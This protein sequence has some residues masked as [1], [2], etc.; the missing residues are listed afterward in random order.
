[1]AT[2]ILVVSSANMDLNMK[3]SELPAKG[4]TIMGE[5]YS[6][7][8]GGKGANSA[9]AFARLGGECCFCAAVGNDGNGDIL[10]DVYKKDGI[11]TSFVK[12]CTDAPT[13][14]A[15]VMVEADGANRIC[16][17]SGANSK[18]EPSDAVDAINGTSP[19]ALFC[20]FEIP[21]STVKAALELC[22][23]KGIPSFVD[24]GPASREYPLE[25]LPCVTVF[26]PN[27]TETEIYTGIRPTDTASCREA[28]EKLLELV[29]ARYIV[30]KLGGKGA[31]VYDCAKKSDPVIVPSYDVT[32]VDTTSAGDAFTAALALEYTRSGDMLRACRYGNVVGALTVSRVGAGDSVPR[33][34][35]CECFIRQ[36][37]IEL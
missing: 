23:R 3:L 7:V 22:S 9:T 8:P 35:E 14:L 33:A 32:V 11:D 19:D 30:I 5:G 28:A 31:A 12:R 26:S 24:A 29:K 34:D 25:E 37:G 16:V 4:R 17:F 13:G 20:H 21:F 1:M 2:K 10:L 6:Y 36:R 18:L 15:T 27:E